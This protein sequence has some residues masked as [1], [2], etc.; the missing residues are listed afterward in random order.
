MLLSTELRLPILKTS[1]NNGVLQVTPFIDLGTGWNNGEND[2]NP[3]TLV[4]AGLGL[5]WQQ[6][7]FA[8][9][10]DY[11]I[12]L[13]SIDT[14]KSTLQDNGIYFSLRYNPSF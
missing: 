11:G 10:I 2:P 3:N 6:G 14:D 12:P 5:L 1:R 4:G 8:A 9:R 7:N 13:V